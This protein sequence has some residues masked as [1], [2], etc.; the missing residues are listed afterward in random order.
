MTGAVQPIRR[1]TGACLLVV[2]A[3]ATV[4][5]Q[6]EPVFLRPIE[7][8]RHVLISE[9]SEAPVR[10]APA[11]WQPTADDGH[12]IGPVFVE[13]TA[14]QP[15]DEQ[16]SETGDAAADEAAGDDDADDNGESDNGRKLLDPGDSVALDASDETESSPLEIFRFNEGALEWTLR[17]SDTGGVGFF[18]FNTGGPAWNLEFDAPSTSGVDFTSGINFVSGPSRPGSDLPERLYDFSWHVHTWEP[19][20]LEIESLDLKL[21]LDL[22]F[23]LGVHT[24]FEDSARDGWRFPGRVLLVS[25]TDVP[26]VWLTGGF[27]YL[28]LEHIQMLPAGGLVMRD[29]DASLE[30]FFPRPRLSTRV[31]QDDSTEEWL[32]VLGEYRGQ[33]WAIERSATG[34][35]DIATLSEYR[36]AVGVESVPLRDSDS[37]DEPRTSFFEVSWLF[38]R[39]LE[40][41]S[42]QGNMDLHDTV[43]FRFGSRW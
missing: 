38:N 32:Y 6:T 37:D 25:E 29:D 12:A 21:G 39:D 9:E 4:R 33:G 13:D 31:S 20:F 15:A 27:E 22:S 2:V 3:A 16:P 28:D 11:L 18:T 19:D 24:D 8:A 7:S 5:A 41:R 1:F 40:Y 30:L 23:D 14:Q 34:L 36:L 10:L 42:G 43:M 26:G 17:G 35:A